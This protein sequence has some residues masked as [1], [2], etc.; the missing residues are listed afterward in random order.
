LSGVTI[1]INYDDGNAN[2]STH[3]FAVPYGIVL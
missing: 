2:C 3:G 1:T